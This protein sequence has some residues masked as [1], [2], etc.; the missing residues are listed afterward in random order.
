M[1]T[2]SVK[3]RFNKRYAVSLD[4]LLNVRNTD[5]KSRLF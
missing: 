4:E 5:K 1:A 2:N 3:T